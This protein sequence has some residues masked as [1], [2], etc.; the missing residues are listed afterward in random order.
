MAA[1][2]AEIGEAQVRELV[3]ALDFFPDF[4]H[5]A[6]IEHFKFKF[7]HSVCNSA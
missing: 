3:Q 2:G 5:G 1:A 7:T 4:C 6:G